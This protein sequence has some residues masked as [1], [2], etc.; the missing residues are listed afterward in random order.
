MG[1]MADTNLNI[2]AHEAAN[3]TSEILN[4]FQ[5]FAVYIT[6]G[7]LLIA[8]PTLIFLIL[9]NS[10]VPV[11]TDTTDNVTPNDPMTVYLKDLSTQ[12]CR[13]HNDA[14]RDF[15]HLSQRL[16]TME[17]EIQ[18]LGFSQTL[19]KPSRKRNVTAKVDLPKLESALLQ[20]RKEMGAHT[21]LL[22]EE[23][24]N[25]LNQPNRNK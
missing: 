15:L 9:R 10:V 12:I 21:C 7:F 24:V 22:R 3:Y 6:L 4:V 5:P 18:A 11:D 8:C 20:L 2:L 17:A 25:T 1:C 14:K 23:I 16:A 19:E 13:Y